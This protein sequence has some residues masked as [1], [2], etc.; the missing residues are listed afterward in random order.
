MIELLRHQRGALTLR[1]AGS[2]R[3]LWRCLLIPPTTPTK[4]AAHGTGR[5]MSCPPTTPARRAYVAHRGLPV[6]PLAVRVVYSYDTHQA[7]RPRHGP[8]HRMPSHDTLEARIRCASRAPLCALWRCVLFFLLRHPP[9]APPTA[10]AD[11]CNALLRH[12]RGACLLR[13]W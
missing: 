6:C 7:R 2:P 9:G 1:F 13:Q 10:R 3:A 4:R 5:R 12:P 8:T 11:A